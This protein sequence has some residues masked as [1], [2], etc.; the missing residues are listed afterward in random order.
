MENGKNTGLLGF[1]GLIACVAL[2]FVVRKFFPSLS[3][4]ML[5]IFGIAA[6]MIVVLVAVVLFFAFHKPKK[7]PEQERS[8]AQETVLK[9]ARASL[10]ELRTSA[11]RVKQ[12][13]VREN[14]QNICVTLEQILKELKNQP[15]DIVKARSFLNHSLP[16]LSGILK[17]YVRLEQSGVPAADDAEKVAV[18]LDGIQVAMRKMYDSLY[19]D[20]K[21]DLTV[22]IETLKQICR[23]DGLLA[24]DVIQIEDGEQNITLSL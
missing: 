17:K 15:E 4:L 12:Q 6:A 5:W 18:C 7:T 2:Y 8:E 16:M 3:T 9:K 24:E 13:Q 22:E 14:A 21:L 20:D 19:T 10:M 23:R 11:M 1:L